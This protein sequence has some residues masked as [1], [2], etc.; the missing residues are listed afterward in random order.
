[1]Q[2]ARVDFRVGLR[3]FCRNSK[4]TSQAQS[5]TRGLCAPHIIFISSAVDA[6]QCER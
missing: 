3:A 4:Q 2:R 6:R 1:M 5:A